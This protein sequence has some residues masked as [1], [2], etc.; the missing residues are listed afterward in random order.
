MNL[1]P[2]HY[3][4]SCMACGHVAYIKQSKDGEP[5]ICAA[6]GAC[7]PRL[8]GLGVEDKL[9]LMVSKLDLNK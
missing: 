1:T 7:A 8:G 4:P 6:I 5:G 2:G 3:Q 9:L